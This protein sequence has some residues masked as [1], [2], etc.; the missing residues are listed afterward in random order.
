MEGLQLLLHTVCNPPPISDNWL[1]DDW[2]TTCFGPPF[3][4]PTLSLDVQVV[5]A[6]KKA[7]AEIHRAKVTGDW[8]GVSHLA[9]ALAIADRV[10]QL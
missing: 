5:W 4:H 8:K 9:L 6:C 7:T 1:R 3:A 2:S 10:L